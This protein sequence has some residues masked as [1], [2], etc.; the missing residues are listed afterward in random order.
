MVSVTQIGQSLTLATLISERCRNLGLSQP[1]FVSRVGCQNI[2]K[3]I[4]LLHQ[5]FDA[6]HTKTKALVEAISAALDLP[7]NVVYRAAQV[8]EQLLGDR[9]RRNLK[10]EAATGRA[11][12]SVGPI[13]PYLRLISD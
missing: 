12:K 10:I 4:W 9:K 5:L 7:D 8:S 6:D 13:T 2:E 11:E 1:E 3:G